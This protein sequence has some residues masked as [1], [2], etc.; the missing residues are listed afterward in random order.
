M[1]TDLA[2]S[3]LSNVFNDNIQP[4][5]YRKYGLGF[6]F[7]FGF[8]LCIFSVVCG[9]FLGFIDKKAQNSVPPDV[10]VN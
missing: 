10:N 7:W 3:R 4:F 1:G 2:I 8:G 9:L 6:G 5:F